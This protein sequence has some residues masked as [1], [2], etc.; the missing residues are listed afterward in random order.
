MWME[1]LGSIESWKRTA[2]VCSSRKSQPFKR[3]RKGKKGK[4]EK[5]REAKKLF[6]Q[7][8]GDD[9][10]CLEMMPTGEWGQKRSKLLSWKRGVQGGR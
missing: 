10:N 1:W 2:C 3:D 4:R 5:E 8:F 9:G 6:L 7:S